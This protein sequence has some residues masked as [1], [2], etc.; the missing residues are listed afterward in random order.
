[1]NIIFITI[2]IIC[3]ICLGLYFKNIALLFFGIYF[4]FLIK[5]KNKINIVIGV[6][7][8]FVFYFY[9]YKT[10]E[11]YEISYKQEEKIFGKLKIIS[12]KEEKNYK[13]KYIAKFKN[14]KFII[15]ID[16]SKNL[17]YGD[18]L[19][20]EGSFENSST[21]KN[22]GGFDYSRYLRQNKIYGNLNLENFKKIAQEKDFFYYLE[23]VKQNL[24]KN[25]FKN[26]DNQKAGFLSGLLLGDKNE[27]L[28]ETS[29]IFRNSSLS[30]IL[31]LSGLHIVYVSFGIR[32]L[33]DF[34]FPIER[35]K[36]FIMIICLIFFAIFTG[37]SPSCIRA[38]IMS[39]MLLFSRIVYRKNDFITSLFI[40]LDIILIIN[41]YNIESI[42]MWLS[43]LSTFGLA[44]IRF[45][46]DFEPKKPNL[47]LKLKTKFL[48]SLKTSFSCNLMIL[49]VVWNT[50]NTVSLTFFISNFFASFLIGPIIILGYVNLFLGKFGF[51]IIENFLVNIL[52]K[53]AEIIGNFRFSKIYVSS[54]PI[55]FWKIYYLVIFL[56]I[57]FSK[58]KNL[59]KIIINYLKDKLK[60][61]GYVFILLILILPFIF[62]KKHNLE[63]HFLDVGQG[64]STLII[65]PNNKK[66]LID[67]GNN[68]G[69]D[70]GEKVITPYLL[71]NGITEIDYIIVS[72]R[73]FGSYWWA[74]FYFRKFE[75]KKYS[76]FLSKRKV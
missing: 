75:S 72:H 4:V 61:L 15:Y 64:D 45:G 40:A 26:F 23:N 12:S 17:E 49:P 36:N 9:S 65:T 57:Y 18:I 43:F 7:I 63:I 29:E 52:F 20:F 27:V 11:S 37:G 70:N 73:R 1:M 21:S 6:L 76:N 25:L 42:G 62:L 69:F 24:E 33:L 68:E 16:K 55:I 32:F 46:K 34:I 51:P 71:K 10:D 67:G 22:F 54:L 28:D 14:K 56:I 53:I 74:L 5:S 30:H 3:G 35:L 47:L 19:Y 31:A 58:R 48:S 2:N 44:Y 39:S 13:N 60:Y 50:Y 59:F 41:C 66:I 38:C 8:C